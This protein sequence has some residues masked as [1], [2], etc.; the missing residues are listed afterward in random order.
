MPPKAKPVA[1]CAMA[2]KTKR[3]I[4]PKERGTGGSEVVGA[5]DDE[6]TAMSKSSGIP[7]NINSEH[8]VSI[9]E[10]LKTIFE[11]ELFENVQESNAIGLA[12]ASTSAEQQQGHKAAFDQGALNNAMT[13]GGVGLY[14]SGC[15]FLGGRPPLQHRA[16][17]SHQCGCLT[18][19][20]NR[21]V[22]C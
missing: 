11:H 17:H 5:E 18:L 12:A 4:K 1:L 19:H 6:A 2:P 7:T 15:N 10:D 3:N 9:E 22:H 8:L 16:W 20:P 13:E 21:V 14:D